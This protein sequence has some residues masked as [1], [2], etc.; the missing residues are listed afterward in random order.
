MAT[1]TERFKAEMQREA[2]AKKPHGKGHDTAGKR[3]KERGRTKDRLPNP[4]SHNEAPSAGKN[5][6]Y[7]LEFS[8]TA[9]PSR[10]STRGS[11]G[12]LKTD[13]AL[14]MVAMN[15]N[16][17]PKVRAQRPRAGGGH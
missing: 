6:T 16:V 15:R 9:R 14:R 5:S 8:Q 7:E 1:K 10:K 11:A 12:H 17:S 4:T 2:Q 13:T 3:A